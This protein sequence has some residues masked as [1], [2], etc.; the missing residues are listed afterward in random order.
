MDIYSLLNMTL[1]NRSLLNTT[2]L[3]CSVA[4]TTNCS[5][6]ESMA[7]SKGAIYEI[8]TEE[9]ILNV[10]FLSIIG[11]VTICGNII[12]LHAFIVSPELKRNTYYFIA[13]LCVSDLMIACL[14]IPSWLIIVKNNFKVPN[15]LMYFQSCLD[16][17]CGTLSIMSL[18]MIGVERFI[19]IKHALHYHRIM[20]TRRVFGI[21][22]S[23]IF[24][25]GIC[26][27]I[28][29]FASAVYQAGTIYYTAL[30]CCILL[31]AFVIPVS[32]KIFSYGNIYLEAKRQVAQINKH[33]TISLGSYVD[34][35]IGTS[36]TDI[37]EDTD[38]MG[39]RM[40]HS[41]SRVSWTTSPLAIRKGD[42]R[43]STRDSII[44]SRSSSPESESLSNHE[45][46]TSPT[47]PLNVKLK[48]FFKCL[49]RKNGENLDYNEN[50]NFMNNGDANQRKSVVSR[51]STDMSV[52][53]ILKKKSSDEDDS[54]LM[55][56]NFSKDE[57]KEVFLKENDDKRQ[58]KAASM[59]EDLKK[60][61]KTQK[62]VDSE[63]ERSR[64]SS[65]PASKL[66]RKSLDVNTLPS[67]KE[68][69]KGSSSPFLR[70]FRGE[71]RGSVASSPS[72]SKRLTKQRRQEQKIR[73]FKKEIRAAKVVGLIMG[74]F[75]MCW[76]P[77]MIFIVLLIL[78]KPPDISNI[79][80]V[81]SLHY[82]NSAINPILYVLLNKVYRKAVIKAFK[83]LKTHFHCD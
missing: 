23:I 45:T 7:A 76:L 64:A 1:T 53:S 39:P 42:L 30:Q 31:M 56:M 15:S 69:R 62:S 82:I 46:P 18:A 35:D 50:L 22:T 58:R 41:N 47:T 11:T 36:S 66:V 32:L 3:N 2:R 4:N 70:R 51:Q 24:Y 28:N 12:A 5:Y 72:L 29:Y 54:Y 26:T 59:Q 40:G 17:F 77:F 43:D 63:E 21:I 9:Q 48:G 61:F 75:L 37:N 60:L 52:R 20:T 14:S 6:T 71:S 73:R 27:I 19:C 44:T 81:V 34:S 78:K 80:I 83:K 67:V 79:V 38:S 25:A 33:Q 8:S 68:E 74:T 57:E 13:S 10:I 49:N 65:L 55:E 16:I